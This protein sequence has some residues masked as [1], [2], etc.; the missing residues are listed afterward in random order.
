M[1]DVM[2]SKA[3]HYRVFLSLLWYLI[4]CTAMTRSEISEM[5]SET[6]A[7]LLNSDAGAGVPQGMFL[8]VM[9]VEFRPH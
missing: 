2:Y 8:F 3:F 5:N 7:V 1:K 4:F 6:G 9:S